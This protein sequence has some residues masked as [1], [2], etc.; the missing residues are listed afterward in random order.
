MV[1]S[2]S[3][4]HIGPGSKLS[5][6]HQNE[7][8]SHVCFSGWRDRLCGFRLLP[9]PTTTRFHWTF[10]GGLSLKD[11]GLLHAETTNS[12]YFSIDTGYRN[13]R[14]ERIS[15]PPSVSGLRELIIKNDGPSVKKTSYGS[16]ELCLKGRNNRKSLGARRKGYYRKPLIISLTRG[17]RRMNKA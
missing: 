3:P 2:D 12:L 7:S 14:L 17:E 15:P 13:D 5:L 16:E 4:P 10:N 6:K 9:S 11:T 1:E 8:F